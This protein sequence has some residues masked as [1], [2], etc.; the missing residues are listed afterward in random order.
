MLIAKKQQHIKIN[1]FLVLILCVASCN[2]QG[3]VALPI[4]GEEKPDA[5][6][7]ASPD[8]D[9]YF[10]APHATISPYGPQSITRNMLQDKVGNMWFASWEG[11]IRYDG[12]SFRNFTILAGLRKYHMFSVMEDK[13]GNIWFG[14]EGGVYRYD[15]KAVGDFR[16]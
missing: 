16:D 2:G 7:T 15:G 9:P 3:N 14:R 11:I 10:V 1:Y 4:N 6:Q 12:E 13:A 5:S 8:V